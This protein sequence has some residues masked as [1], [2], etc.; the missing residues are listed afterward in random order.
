MR[1]LK[2]RENETSKLPMGKKSKMAFTA[3][4]MLVVALSYGAAP[5]LA[6][7]NP[8]AVVNN[9][10]DIMFGLVRAV[11]TII[12]LWGIVQVGMSIQSHDPSQRA[13]GFL[14]AIGGI[15]IALA[16]EILDLIMG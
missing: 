1:K 8:I 16:K 6:A 11:G 14:V 7:N 13:N 12:A 2:V 10:S 15:V 5:A 3:C 4:A 9:L